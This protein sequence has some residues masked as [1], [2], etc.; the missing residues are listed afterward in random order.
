[1]SGP[2]G[3]RPEPRAGLCAGCRHGIRQASVR[4]SVF[5]RCALAER[6]PRFVRYPPLPVLA[7]DGFE[8]NARR[9]QPPER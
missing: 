6:D 3:P 9:G 8:T 7:C 2:G 1:V 4:G 5:W